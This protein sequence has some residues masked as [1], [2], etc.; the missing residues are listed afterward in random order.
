MFGGK[1]VQFSSRIRASSLDVV[2]F[3]SPVNARSPRKSMI[4]RMRWPGLHGTLDE[5]NKCQS[6]RF[7]SRNTRWIPENKWQSVRFYSRN[8]R[9]IPENKCQRVRSYSLTHVWSMCLSFMC[10]PFSYL[11]FWYDTFL[12]SWLRPYLLCYWCVNSVYMYTYTSSKSQRRGSIVSFV[13]V[14]F[15]TFIFR[16]KTLNSRKDKPNATHL[17]RHE[18]LHAQRS[19]TDNEIRLK[20]FLSQRKHKE[21][22]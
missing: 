2:E 6:V 10:Y 4:P 14:V 9:R 21:K 15:Q 5:R 11:D 13:I 18:L 1:S 16:K 22:K 17:W 20:F 19:L 8:T 12:G 3:T 7:Y